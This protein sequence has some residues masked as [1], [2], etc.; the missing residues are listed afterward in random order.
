MAER[1][2][3]EDAGDD[4][5]RHPVR[6]GRVRRLIDGAPSVAEYHGVPDGRCAVR[7]AGSRSCSTSSGL[8]HERVTRSKELQMLDDAQPRTAFPPGQVGL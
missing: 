7:C 6:G 4:T 8:D 2:G 5:A 3:L 1:T